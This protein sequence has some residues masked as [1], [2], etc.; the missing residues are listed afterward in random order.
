MSSKKPLKYRTLRRI[1]NSFGITEIKGRGKGSHRMF[2][3]VVDGR[4]VHYPTKCHSEGDD[5]PI[6]VVEAIRRAFRLTENDGVSDREF[7]GRA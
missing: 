5:K 3:G 1:L 7:Y 6:A 4:L 2:Q